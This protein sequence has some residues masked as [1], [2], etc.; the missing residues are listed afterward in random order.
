MQLIKYYERHRI[1]FAVDFFIKRGV[2]DEFS[3]FVKDIPVKIERIIEIFC[4]NLRESGF[5]CLP[6]A[7][8]KN[9]LLMCRKPLPDIFV[10]YS[11]HFHGGQYKAVT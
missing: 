7:G 2:F 6:R 9:H 4:Q 10:K 11:F 8:N 5:T 3:L 1:V